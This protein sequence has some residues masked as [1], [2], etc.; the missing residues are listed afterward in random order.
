MDVRVVL[1]VIGFDLGAKGAAAMILPGGSWRTYR[2]TLPK[3]G[4]RERAGWWYREVGILLEWDPVAVAYEDPHFVGARGASQLWIRRQEGEL[5]ALCDQRDILCVPAPTPTVRAHAVRHGAPKWAK[6]HAKEAMREGAIIRGWP[7][8]EWT[9][10][11]VD[12]AWVADWLHHQ[13]LEVEP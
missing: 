13:R 4:D 12:A 1:P 3:Y 9:E 11:E 6:G 8:A 7:C 2:L 10:D 5:L